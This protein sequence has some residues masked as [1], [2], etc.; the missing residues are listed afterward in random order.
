MTAPPERLIRRDPAFLA[1]VVSAVILAPVSVFLLVRGGEAFTAYVAAFAA[2]MAWEWQR[3]ADGGAPT[4][5]YA[6]AAVAAS[7]AV[8][9]VGHGDLFWAAAWPLA[10][11]IGVA[12]AGDIPVRRR[13]RA[14]AGILY[15]A[16]TSC[17]LVWMRDAGD[18]GLVR[19]GFLM[20][21]VWSADIFAYFAGT[22]LG[23][24][25]L[26]P[27]VSPNKTWAGFAGAMVVGTFAGGLYARY[28]GL[29]FPEAVILAAVLALAS[30]LGDLLMSLAK[31]RFGVKDAGKIIPGHGGV[32]D[33]VD[34]LMLATAVALA[35]QLLV[36]QVWS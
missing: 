3:M 32:L 4:R 1:R 28:F 16:L 5:S 25:K 31:R 34:A 11:A 15:V 6:V 19:L 21:V 18:N 33:R 17:S 35:S 22:W 12:F 26:W 2:A 27:R 36:P 10:G 30:V 24:P 14:P 7:G 23:G 13:W 20:C 29:P 8:I 9:F